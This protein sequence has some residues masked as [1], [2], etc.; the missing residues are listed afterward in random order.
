MGFAS[1]PRVALDRTR[2]KGNV[3]KSS[4]VPQRPREAVGMTRLD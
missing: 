3:D 1:S 2:W 4:V